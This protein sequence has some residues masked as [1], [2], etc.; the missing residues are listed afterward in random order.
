M[1]YRGDYRSDAY[2]AREGF[3]LRDG[4]ARAT[5]PPDGADLKQFFAILYRNRVFVGGATLAALALAGAYLATAGTAYT[6]TVSILID[7]RTRPPVGADLPSG[8]NTTPDATLVESQVK[9]IASDTVLRRVVESE[10]L[11]DDPAFVPTRP[12]LRT[13]LF[14]M[15]GIGATTTGGEDRVSRAIASLSRSIVVKRSERTYIIDVDLMSGDANK[16]A[17]LANLVAE[18][19][20]A[21]QRDARTQMSR[22]DFRWLN[23]RLLDLQG[24]LQDAEN[25]VQEFRVKNRITDAIG[26]NVGEQELSDLTNELGRA[27]A[28]AIDARAKYDQVQKLAAL[29]KAPESTADALKSPVLDKLRAQYAEI[30]RQEAH[31]RTLGERHPA[32]LEIQNQL[33]DSRLLIAAELKR[34][35]ETAGN[36]YQQA[37]AAEIETGRRV[38]TARLS[39]DSKNQNMVQLRELDRELE[40]QKTAYEKFL[41]ARENISDDNHDGPMARVIAPASAPLTPSSPKTMAI[42]IIA[43]FSGLSVGV[44]ASLLRDYLAGSRLIPRPHS[45]SVNDDPAENPIL[46]IIASV[47]RI[48]EPPSNLRTIKNWMASKQSSEAAANPMPILSELDRNPKS[49]F[50]AAIRDLYEDLAPPQG[51][52]RRRKRATKILVS[53]AQ[54]G[55]GKTTI[56]VNLARAAAQ[57]GQR[58]LLIDANIKHPSLAVLIEPGGL[59]GLIELD[60]ALRPLYKIAAGSDAELWVVPMV[61]SEQQITRE[62]AQRP[63]VSHTVG[64]NGNFDFVVID[65]STLERSDDARSIA[66]AV[67]RIV[68]VAAPDETQLSIEE[69]TDALDVPEDK[70]FGTVLSMVETRRAA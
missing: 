9:L 31:Y 1:S 68:L 10:H 19:Y 34:V 48:G 39:T 46:H 15:L 4:Y 26:K 61:D 5:N 36:D 3:D 58:T 32:M 45:S 55:C 64:I 67:D 38:E 18:A 44:G 27:R 59:A 56:A 21:D 8:V 16:A 47:P 52:R 49:D 25:K 28:R 57:A 24:R 12:G 51:Q 6:A 63:D 54:T 40:A 43:L 23:Q 41:R 33:R 60:G 65:G 70:L 62:L 2:S 35:A 11:V 22:Q 20:I 66:D 53:S 42:L 50:S 7:A 14:A 13:R 30:A 17:R 29:G 37:R 69:L